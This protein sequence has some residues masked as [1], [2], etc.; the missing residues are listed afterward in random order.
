[1]GYALV[2]NIF[3][4]IFIFQSHIC[5][6]DVDLDVTCASMHPFLNDQRL[7]FNIGNCVFRVPPPPACILKVIITFCLLIAVEH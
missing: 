3:A 7:R 4:M 2:G 1:M 5:T 6:L